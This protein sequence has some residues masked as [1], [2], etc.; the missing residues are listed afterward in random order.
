M[1]T[2]GEIIQSARLEKNISV[3]DVSNELKISEQIINDFECDNIQIMTRH[4]RAA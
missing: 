4:S 1:N 3:K 2:V